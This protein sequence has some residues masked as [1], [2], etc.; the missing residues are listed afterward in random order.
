MDFR[1]H[2]IWLRNAI[3]FKYRDLD[4][5]K[6]GVPDILQQCLDVVKD[7]LVNTKWFTLMCEVT[8]WRN[9]SAWCVSFIDKVM[10]Q[11]KSLACIGMTRRGRWAELRLRWLLQGCPPSNVYDDVT[12]GGQLYLLLLLH[13]VRGDLWPCT[14]DYDEWFVC[15]CICTLVQI[16]E[17]E[18]D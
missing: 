4:V 12:W 14:R 15:A 3:P 6:N 11:Q 10:L 9:G 2:S 8:Y 13:P 1:P 5:H 17:S 16:Q 7:S 18:N